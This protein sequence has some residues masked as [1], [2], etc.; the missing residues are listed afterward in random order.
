M[1]VTLTKDT[2]IKKY[3][4]ITE[5]L[6]ELFIKNGKETN[7]LKD[8]QDDMNSFK[9][10]VPIIGSFSA[11][12][13]TLLNTFLEEKKLL[14][15]NI[16]AET[17][18]PTEIFYGEQEK[19]CVIS[20]SGSQSISKEQIKH[21][22]FYIENE[23]LLQVQLPNPHL[24]EV[25]HVVL[26]DLPGLDSGID[27]HSIAI[28]Q[29][30]GKSMAYFI[31]VDIEYG[32]KKSVIDFLSELK[33]FDLPVYV[34]VTKKDK[35]GYEIENIIG[36]TRKKIEKAIGH[37]SFQ[38]GAVSSR[39][40]D[41]HAF[42]TYVHELEERIPEIFERQYKGE[43][44]ETLSLLEKE[45]EIR[46][47]HESMSLEEITYEEENLHNEMNRF[48]NE[49]SVEG[50]KLTA[51][52]HTSVQD[53][54]ERVRN[55]LMDG[56]ESLISSILNQ[57]DI[58]SQITQIVRKSV[59]E[60]MKT[61]IEPKVKRFL[62]SMG[63]RLAEEFMIQGDF[64]LGKIGSTTDTMMKDMLKKSIPLILAG[65]GLALSGPIVAIVAGILSLFVDLGFEKKQQMEQ[66]KK[67][68]EM[69]Y[70]DVIPSVVNNVEMPLQQMIAEY[71]EEIKRSVE[72]KM[73][74]KEQY[75][76]EALAK[77]REQKAM[78]VE[79]WEAIRRELENDL[80]KVVTLRESLSN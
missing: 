36:D 10:R 56:S 24:E 49:L 27:A 13:S 76:L 34:L 79:E 72:K 45:L 6:H 19:F 23:Q 5:E 77:L 30:I 68:E 42:T 3:Q 4:Q 20:K 11:G 63:N 44:L 58:N 48:M 37:S 22:D 43:L 32:I 61:D 62:K 18:I 12:K 17:A 2:L 69:V 64:N 25:K 31:A 35:K 1:S 16:S 46:L 29:Y 50:D 40:G 51:Q 14:A 9:V 8:M 53:I 26:V 67:A 65:I 55:S 75:M 59:I 80:Q 47:Q 60:G 28:D 70:H 71:I 57:R 41:I 7:R 21:N 78:Q 54:L 39:K 52:L 15:T 74:E 38:I 73:H 66:R 33:F